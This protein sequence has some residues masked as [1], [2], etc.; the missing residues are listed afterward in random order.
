MTLR[1]TVD[2]PAKINRFLLIGP[3][4]DDGYHPIVSAMETVALSDRITVTCLTPDGPFAWEGQCHHPSLGDLSRSTVARALEQLHQLHPLRGTWHIRLEK[5]IPIGSGLG[6]GSSDA[7]T[8]LLLFNRLLGLELPHQALLTLARKIG[9]DV[10]FFLYGGRALAAGIGDRI[11]P[12]PDPTETRPVIIVFPDQP[13]PTAQMYAYLDERQDWDASLPEPRQLLSD[14]T[15]FND[16]LIEAPNRFASLLIETTPW[17][18]DLLE[19]LRS[20]ARIQ[21]SGSGGAF[22][23]IPEHGTPVALIM[24]IVRN[25]IPPSSFIKLTSFLPRSIYWDRLKI[26]VPLYP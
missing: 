7:A 8:I 26:L 18:P 22:W 21:W 19:A 17:W 24:E 10:P 4:R 1:W 15:R 3:P 9:A 5:R 16:L 23:I 25:Y 6:G 20:R 13:M 12:L 14:E 11:Y 2:V